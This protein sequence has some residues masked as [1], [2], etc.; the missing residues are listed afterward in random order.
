MY[1]S[2]AGGGD[3]TRGARAALS[4][5]ILSL[6]RARASA[7][8]IT[9]TEISGGI[10]A[11]KKINNVFSTLVCTCLHSNFLTLGYSVR[12]DIIWIKQLLAGLFRFCANL[13]LGELIRW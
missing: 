9:H 2:S 8:R 6:S 4:I 12:N 7:L 5:A 3:I 13:F 11:T 1:S 10:K